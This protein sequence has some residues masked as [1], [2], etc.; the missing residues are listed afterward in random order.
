MHCI[1]MQLTK[2]SQVIKKSNHIPAR[3]PRYHSRCGRHRH[4][5]RPSIPPCRTPHRPCTQTDQRTH[6]TLYKTIKTSVWQYWNTVLFTQYRITSI[7]EIK[8]YRYLSEV[9]YTP[10]STAC[11]MSCVRTFCRMPCHRMV[12]H[13]F[14]CCTPYCRRHMVGKA[15][16][17]CGYSRSDIPNTAIP[18]VRTQSS[19]CRILFQLTASLI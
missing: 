14:V 19:V 2:Q 18:T 3:P 9:V 15:C 12:G 6:Q 1:T 11:H 5:W 4:G 16:R 17:R 7:W 8:F 10:V 13:R